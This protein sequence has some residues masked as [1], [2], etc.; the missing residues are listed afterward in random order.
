M[1]NNHRGPHHPDPSLRSGVEGEANTADQPE[2]LSVID[3][4][5]LA[6]DA[7]KVM[8]SLAWRDVK[9][10]QQEVADLESEGGDAN[11]GTETLM[12]PIEP[13]CKSPGKLRGRCENKDVDRS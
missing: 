8:L 5:R 6:L 13:G 9:Y 3:R 1:K 7:A 10:W 11:K 2:R 12:I 4:R